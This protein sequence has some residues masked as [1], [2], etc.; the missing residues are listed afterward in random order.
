MRYTTVSQALLLLALTIGFGCP[1]RA[2]AEDSGAPPWQRATQWPDRI[3]ATLSADPTRSFSVTWRTDQSIGETIAQIAP[4]S[5]DARFD[6]NAESVTARTENVVLDSIPSPGGPM[7]AIHN[8]GLAPVNYHSV[9]FNKLTPETLYAYRVRGARGMWSPWR[10]L[11]TAPVDG[12]VRFI[13]FGDAQTGIRSHVTRTIDAASVAVPDARFLI[14]GGDLVNRAFY[15]KEWAEWFEAGGRTYTTIPSL[16]VAGNH[17]YLNFSGEKLFTAERMVTPLWRPQFT[18]P[19]ETGLPS[20]LHET[21]YALL[22][23]RNL[24]VFVI[25]S[26]GVAYDEQMTWLA[27]SLKA[28]TAKWRVVTMHHPFFSFVGEDEADSAE[29]RRLGLMAV[30]EQNDVD[31]VL[32]GHRH[33]YQRAE[34]GDGVAQAATMDA[35]RVDTVFV[36]T[37]TSTRRGYTKVEGWKEYEESQD[38]RFKLE[39]YGDYIPIYG[40]IAIDGDL[41]SYRALDATGGVYDAFTLHKDGEGIKTIRNGAEATEPVRNKDNAGPYRE[42]NDLR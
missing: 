9:T 32:T 26:S 39:R 16:P 25:D 36:V 19:V 6:L 2:P 15:D 13:F 37:A 40:D 27:Q 10:Q 20:A 12:P 14:H 8:L 30:L 3:I 5:A 22:Y 18:L 42:W 23:S 7:P 11:R 35:H 29:D 4:A 21:V 41:L 24:H 28:S 38:G 31:L 1:D 34:K 33:S 17:D